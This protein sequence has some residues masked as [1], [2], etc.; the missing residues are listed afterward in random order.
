[1]VRALPCHGRGRGFE[2]RRLRSGIFLFTKKM[3]LK[4]S[5]RI[6]KT[7]GKTRTSKGAGLNIFRLWP[8]EVS[9]STL[10]RC[11]TGSPPVQL[12]ARSEAG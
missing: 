6:F 9:L 8:T 2:S 10:F 4:V 7:K 12:P 3:T 5:G 11:F 1:M